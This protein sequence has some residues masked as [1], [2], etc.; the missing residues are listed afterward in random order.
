MSTVDTS[1]SSERP[2]VQFRMR[3]R[4]RSL[5]ALGPGKIELLE[6]I[7]QS[8][9]ISAAA[10]AMNMSYRRAWLLIDEINRALREPVVETSTGGTH[11]GGARL[12]ETGQAVIRHYRTIEEIAHKAAAKDLQALIDLLA[13]DQ[14]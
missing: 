14:A 13:P 7:Q 11:G 6:H 4:H 8:G 5:I 10:R 3:I 12:T 1:D 9:S 2:S